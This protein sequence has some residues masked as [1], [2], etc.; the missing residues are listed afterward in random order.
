MSMSGTKVATAEEVRALVASKRPS[1]WS[2]GYPETV[3]ER[4]R[5]YA[6][7]RRAGGAT[8]SLVAEELGLS[9]HSIVTW[10]APARASARL[11]PVT[12]VPDAEPAPVPA[13]SPS[14]PV[15]ISPRGYRVE[16]L[17]ATGL[18]ALLATVG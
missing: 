10:T 8:A 7:A 17:D 12:V 14:A 13:P 4:V 16:G 2:L 6:A 1:S 18:A 9:R 5:A 3:R 11:R 15:L